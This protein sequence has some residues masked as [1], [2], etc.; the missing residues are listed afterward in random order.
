MAAYLKV[1]WA[2]LAGNY[3]DRFLSGLFDPCSLRHI[4]NAGGPCKLCIRTFLCCSQSL[5]VTSLYS[6]CKARVSSVSHEPLFPVPPDLFSYNACPCSPDAPCTD[7]S[8]STIPFKGKYSKLHSWPDPF[9]G[10][11]HGHLWWPIMIPPSPSLRT[12]SELQSP[13][14]QKT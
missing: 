3:Y 6:A 7:V 1:T 2:S 13:G 12:S 14:N 8:L 4:L 9:P 11:Y 5:K 10:A